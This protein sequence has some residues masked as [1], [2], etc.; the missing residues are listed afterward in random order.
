MV[1]LLRAGIDIS[2]GCGTRRSDPGAVIQAVT[3][4]GGTDRIVEY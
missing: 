2:I 3:E 1:S 4:S